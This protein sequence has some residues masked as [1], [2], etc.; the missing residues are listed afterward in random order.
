MREKVTVAI[1]AFITAVYLLYTLSMTIILTFYT[2]EEYNE[3]V[4]FLIRNLAVY[5]YIVGLVIF[6]LLAIVFDCLTYRKHHYAFKEQFWTR[7]F[8][9]LTVIMTYVILL[10]MIVLIRHG[11][12]L[13]IKETTILLTI[14]ESLQ[15]L[16]L[17]AITQLSSINNDFMRIYNRYPDQL[18][19]VSIIQYN[20]DNI[21]F[22][23]KT[24][25][26]ELL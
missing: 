21:I 18:Y 5:V 1:F 8:V 3:V 22:N 4:D 20:P 13:S 16:P 9:N 7:L 6:T 19:K 24:G 2:V 11:K 26:V 14:V 15:I 10:W 12:L 25:Q 17:V 23:E